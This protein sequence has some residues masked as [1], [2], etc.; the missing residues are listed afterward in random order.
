MCGGG[1]DPDYDTWHRK[2]VMQGEAENNIPDSIVS[3]TA[4]DSSPQN[5]TRPPSSSSSSSSSLLLF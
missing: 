4:P 3:P 1:R 2:S 5:G